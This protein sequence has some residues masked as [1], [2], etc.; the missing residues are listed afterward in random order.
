MGDI[1][2][3]LFKQ[4]EKEGFT[5]SEQSR[6]RKH[7]AK[8]YCAPGGQNQNCRHRSEVLPS[9]CRTR[10]RARSSITL[11]ESIC[12]RNMQEK[13][14]PDQ[15]LRLPSSPRPGITLNLPRFL[16]PCRSG[17][18]WASGRCPFARLL[19]LLVGSWKATPWRGVH[20][21]LFCRQTLLKGNW[22]DRSLMSP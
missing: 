16:F 19:P 15:S 20:T 14:G 11:W 22:C 6:A 10:P 21:R 2:E 4:M 5:G 8:C 18:G 13:A 3:H 17:W 12:N 7:L 9:H 1:N